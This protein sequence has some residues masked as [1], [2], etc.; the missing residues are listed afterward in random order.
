MTLESHLQFFVQQSEKYVLPLPIDVC[1][2]NATKLIPINSQIVG[3]KLLFR[4]WSVIFPFRYSSR[5]AD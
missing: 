2:S 4:V 3:Q 5:I 1:A